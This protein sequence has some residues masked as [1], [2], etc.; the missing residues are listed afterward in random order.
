MALLIK[1]NREL[2]ERVRE[3][4]KKVTDKN[5]PSEE[6]IQQEYDDAIRARCDFDI[7][8][9]DRI[10]VTH[11]D[12]QSEA[13]GAVYEVSRMAVHRD[14]T[15]YRYRG[16]RVTSF[17]VGVRKTSSDFQPQ[18]GSNSTRNLLASKVTWKKVPKDT[19]LS[20]REMVKT[21]RGI[22]YIFTNLMEL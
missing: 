22:K 5:K 1:E 3:L 17:M 14:F 19:P 21:E 9:D 10:V 2:K 7:K 4:E 6:D 8:E 13:V 11:S 18:Y 16:E 12:V 20:H 15:L